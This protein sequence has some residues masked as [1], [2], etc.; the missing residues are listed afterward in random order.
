MI[1]K[2][3]EIKNFRNI[4]HLNI[5]VENLNLIYGKNAQGKTSINK[6][7]KFLLEGTKA[8]V[9]QLKKGEQS[10]L[11]AGTFDHENRECKLTT[12][13]K[14]NKKDEPVVSTELK[15]INGESVDKARTF[16][17]DMIGVLEF[18]IADILNP[19]TL[20]N[21]IDT[22][23]TEE[24]INLIENKTLIEPIYNKN[25]D[26]NGFEV[27]KLLEK[28]LYDE[29]TFNNRDLLTVKKYNEKRS[30]DLINEENLLKD[31]VFDKAKFDTNKETLLKSIATLQ[32][33]KENL[34]KENATTKAYKD[35]LLSIATTLSALESQKQE[36]TN[37]I[38]IQNA[39]HETIAQQMKGRKI[40]TTADLDNGIEKENIELQKLETTKQEYIKVEALSLNKKDL[41]RNIEKENNL[42]KVS[43]GLTNDIEGIR[44][45]LTENLIERF[46]LGIKGLAYIDKVFYL[47]EIAI[48]ELSESESLKVAFQILGRIKKD[49]SIILLDGAEALDDNSY[50]QLKTFLADDK[51][52]FI[53]K[54]GDSFKTVNNENIFEMVDGKIK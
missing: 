20:L 42:I 29:R 8:D 51:N 53:T 13:L 7:V 35:K 10:C 23:V 25:K 4:E 36:I 40:E 30:L 50:K 15:Y 54:V 45:K 33:K 2:K 31:V 19:T 44:G 22:K 37:A 3:L 48:T 47:N 28:I 9:E 32:V 5:D 39:E 41:K 6:A 1:L 38:Q 18:K 12:I 43:D 24:D 49:T 14:L 34:D 16:A 46:D 27:L 17:K 21:K 52:Y 11:V 26:K